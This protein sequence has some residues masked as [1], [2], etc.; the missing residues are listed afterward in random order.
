MGYCV[1]CFFGGIGSEKAH[2]FVRRGSKRLSKTTK[3]VSSL[4][5]DKLLCLCDMV[6]LQVLALTL[7]IVYLHTQR[8][9]VSH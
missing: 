8:I 7:Y 4:F 1:L 6:Y 2:L 5:V 3:S 9:D